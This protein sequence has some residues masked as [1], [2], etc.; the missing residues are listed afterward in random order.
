[1]A[2]KVQDCVGEVLA[3]KATGEYSEIIKE[4]WF[5]LAV[6]EELESRKKA[7]NWKMHMK[8]VVYNGCL[9]NGD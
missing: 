2:N 1:M 9:L 5:R 7:S 6:R 4:E 8:D 3:G